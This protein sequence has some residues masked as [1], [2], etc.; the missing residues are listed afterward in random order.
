MR[1]SPAAHLAVKLVDGH[2]ERVVDDRNTDSQ[3]LLN[4]R[5]VLWL[6]VPETTPPILHQLRVVA[7]LATAGT[8]VVPDLGR[9]RRGGG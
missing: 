5:Q 2:I 7:A 6:V 8:S 9:G 1:L 4:V 3:V